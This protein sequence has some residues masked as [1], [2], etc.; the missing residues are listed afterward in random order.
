MKDKI[1][2]WSLLS[3]VVTSQIGSGIMTRPSPMSYLGGIGQW[4]WILSFGAAIILALIF[5]K[6]CEVY[7]QA[8]GPFVYISH[9]FGKK[10]G[11]LTAWS[12]W[13]VSW[14][15]TLSLIVGGVAYLQPFLPKINPIFY[16]CC[17][18][19]VFIIMNLFGIKISSLINVIFVILKILPLI[20]V[21]TFMMMS[22]NMIPSVSTPPNPINGILR[23]AFLTFWGFVGLEVGT[24]PGDFVKNPKQ[25][26]PKAII[27]GTVIVG[28]IYIL[29]SLSFHFL[30][31]SNDLMY[32]PVPYSIACDYIFKNPYVMAI[33][34]SSICFGSLHTWILITADIGYGAAQS[35]FFHK[36]FMIDSKKGTPIS[37]IILSSIGIYPLIFLTHSDQLSQ[38]MTLI[39]D[40]SSVVFLIIYT[41]SSL[42][43]VKIIQNKKWLGWIG[44]AMAIV[45]MIGSS[46]SS[47]FY[48]CVLIVCGCPFLIKAGPFESR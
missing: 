26:I 22:L 9:A 33:L 13:V 10:I 30:I 5:S 28:G 3:L 38:Q 11:F 35:G 12:Y 23:G 7:P 2:F 16:E 6:L 18:V 40:I 29:N 44:F 19:T 41:L 1:G 42:S 32:S 17:V 24:V 15:A 34:G 36:I 4:G 14:V 46:W 45:L 48:S 27:W 31:P 43:Y 25:T 21:P 47:L 8:G 39:L 37:S 20:I